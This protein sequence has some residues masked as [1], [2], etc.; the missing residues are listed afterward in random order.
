MECFFILN[1]TATTNLL[2]IRSLAIAHVG[3]LKKNGSSAGIFIDDG[4]QFKEKEGFIYKREKRV[5]FLFLFYSLS[6][7][8][9]LSIA[10]YK[11]QGAVNC[12]VVS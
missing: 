12:H 5:D 11:V 9:E 1:W 7:G 10:V 4:F 3:L 2:A 6:Y 8:Q